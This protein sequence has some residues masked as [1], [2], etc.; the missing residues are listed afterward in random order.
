MLFRSGLDWL[1]RGS[2][3]VMLIVLGALAVLLLRLRGALGAGTAVAA[4]SVL[5]LCDTW[6]INQVFIKYENPA[7][8]SD[9]KKENARAKQLMRE[10]DDLFR[11]L[12]LPDHHILQQSGLGLDGVPSITG[13]NNL[14]VGR[15]DRVLRHIEPVTNLLWSKY[16]FGREIPYDEADLLTAI[17]PLLNL[18]NGKYLVVPRGIGLIPPADRFPPVGEV[19]N[20]RVYLN[21]QALPWV[22]LAPRAEL[23]A[24]GDEVLEMLRS[25]RVDPSRVALVEEALPIA[26]TNPENVADDRVQVIEHNPPAGRVRLQTHSEEARLLVLSENYQS[27]WSVWVDGKIG[28]AHV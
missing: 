20:Y 23:V 14:T 6:R 11:I 28:R 16:A 4:L 9:I 15:Y 2:T 12:P 1:A 22:Y 19:D 8:Y 21:P 7:A 13:F 3:Y 17:H 10:G 18:L 25:G 5:V 26:L 24:D 27:N